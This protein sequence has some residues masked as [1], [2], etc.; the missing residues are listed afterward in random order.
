MDDTD[1]DALPSTLWGSDPDDDEVLEPTPLEVVEP[2][3]LEGEPT[4]D[5]APV[6]RIVIDVAAWESRRFLPRE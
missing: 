4:S 3:P 5:A 1:L 6:G 2:H